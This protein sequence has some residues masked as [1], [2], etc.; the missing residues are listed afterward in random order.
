MFLATVALIIAGFIG[1]LVI[2]FG[3]GEERGYS[4]GQWDAIHAKRHTKR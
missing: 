1:G 3:I 4:M 2:G